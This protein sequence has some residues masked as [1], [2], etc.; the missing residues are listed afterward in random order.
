VPQSSFLVTPR[1][2]TLRHGPFALDLAPEVGGAIA[3]FSCDW[4]GGFDLMRRLPDAAL[5]AR[6]VRLA[7]C[8]PML[9]YSNRMRECTLAFG[10]RRYR[11]APNFGSH[12]HSI[13]GNAWQRAW[14]VESADAAQATLVL[15]HTAESHLSAEWPFA[16]R[17]RQRFALSND[18]LTVELALENVG[19]GPMPAGMGLHPYFPRAAG[20]RLT[21]LTRAVWRNDEA[22]MPVALDPVPPAWN[23]EEGR[24]VAPL[25]VDNC[26]AGWQGNARIEW[27]DRGVSLDVTADPVFGHLVVYVPPGKTFF[28]VE[29][30]SHANDGMNML[31][32]GRTDSGV[33]V[34]AP[35]ERLAG[36]VLFAVTRGVPAA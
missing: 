19:P 32:K 23:F 12:P 4:D 36:T 8:F 24:L 15:E 30:T 28:C 22:M 20:T 10:G 1:L 18:G 7:G 11:I 25:A 33:V 34:L 35:G 3:A 31:A 16:Y 21:A 29:P 6:D 27:P 26:F 13:H 9:P 2:V 17:A 5:A 14:T